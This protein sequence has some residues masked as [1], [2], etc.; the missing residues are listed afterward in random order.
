MESA[1]SHTF[2]PRGLLASGRACRSQTA[3]PILHPLSRSRLRACFL[4]S[5]DCPCQGLLLLQP[6][7]PSWWP[8]WLHK[9]RNTYCN[10]AVMHRTSRKNPNPQACGRD[11]SPEDTCRA[12]M[13]K[14]DWIRACNITVRYA[15]ATCVKMEGLLLHKTEVSKQFCGQPLPKLKLT[16]LQACCVGSVHTAGQRHRLCRVRGTSVVSCPRQDLGRSG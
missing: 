14:D 15:L 9:G 16:W 13:T 5:S 1:V 7:S 12:G 4:S 2:R 8:R 6:A 11:P 3:R 10:S